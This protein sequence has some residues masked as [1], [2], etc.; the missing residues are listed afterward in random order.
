MRLIFDL[1]SLILLLLIEIEY[2]HLVVMAKDYS[3][4]LAKRFFV[5]Q[6]KPQWQRTQAPREE[7]A[8]ICHILSLGPIECI[9]YNE[10]EYDG[11]NPGHEEYM[12]F[13]I[14]YGM[15]GAV[16]LAQIKTSSR[17]KVINS[18]L[19]E[20][21]GVEK[22][23]IT[24]IVN[25]FQIPKK[26]NNLQI[27]EGCEFDI[28][29]LMFKLQAKPINTNNNFEYSS[30]KEVALKISFH[31]SYTRELYYTSLLS[32]Q[33]FPLIP[34]KTYGHGK[35][36]ITPRTYCLQIEKNIAL[37]RILITEK[38]NGVTMQVLVRW[39]TSI[40]YLNW[41][42]SA[43]T[44]KELQ[45]RLDNRA[46]IIWILIHSLFST[47]TS[48]YIH[49]DFGYIV[50]CDLNTGNIQIANTN[51]NLKG[52]NYQENVDSLLKI[53]PI[54]IKILDF[55]T[56]KSTLEVSVRS[57]KCNT[58]NDIWRIKLIISRLFKIDNTT[59]PNLFG[60]TIDFPKSS[61][62][63][64]YIKRN[65]ILNHIKSLDLFREELLS[66]NDFKNAMDL[67]STFESIIDGLD[68]I[69]DITVNHISKFKE[70]STNIVNSE[71]FYASCSPLDPTNARGMPIRLFKPEILGQLQIPLF[72]DKSATIK[73]TIKEE[74]KKALVQKSIKNNENNNKVKESQNNLEKLNQEILDTNLKEK[75]VLQGGVSP[76]GIHGIGVGS[77]SNSNIP[78][79]DIQYTKKKATRPDTNIVASSIGVLIEG[80][81]DGNNQ[82][83]ALM[84]NQNFKLEQEKISK[85][86]SLKQVCN[87]VEQTKSRDSR[88][89]LNKLKLKN[90]VLR[91]ITIDIDH[92]V[93]KADKILQE[94]T[95]DIKKKPQKS[96]YDQEKLK[97]F[98]INRSKL[99]YV[100]KSCP[101]TISKID[102]E[103]SEAAE[104][105]N[106]GIVAFENERQRI[107]KRC[108]D[109]R[110]F[111]PR[112]ENDTVK[113]QLK[114]KEIIERG[115]TLLQYRFHINDAMKC[116]FDFLFKG[117]RRVQRLVELSQE[118]MKGDLLLEENLELLLD[119]ITEYNV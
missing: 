48:L 92:F 114:T 5:N 52:I 15:F 90:S 82:F 95:D 102:E 39:L 80:N 30:P 19:E 69:C 64:N 29:A 105:V 22:N 26:V 74:R 75:N 33:N 79:K 68:S 37:N 58:P 66:N 35:L 60:W 91:D 96:V 85:I 116:A 109:L 18:E 12:G 111:T 71:R 115:K 77:T 53:T 61:S 83:E 84:F 24:E 63:L 40:D 23:K 93:K 55:G 97:I 36:R 86:S 67:N 108:H 112:N 11:A 119:K 49:S 47:L 57:L 107:L 51:F 101:V 106:I 41:I 110:N 46:E 98:E 100:A 113:A 87:Y 34:V 3:D 70:N 104:K 65:R 50:H 76:G 32:K 42:S 13:F 78:I 44:I 99:R 72:P 118:S 10:R 17:S 38:I 6:D 16:A 25:M 27:I 7:I 88:K 9:K 103:N 62:D 31:S 54:N 73:R 28:N 94:I 43:K 4:K 1:V 2:K 45:R 20:L 21:S 14:Q 59:H 56:T 117:V 8:I 81:T 89:L